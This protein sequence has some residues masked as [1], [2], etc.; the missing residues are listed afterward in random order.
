MIV[1]HP[2]FWAV[3]EQQTGAVLFGAAITDPVSE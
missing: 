3:S 2:F 1:D